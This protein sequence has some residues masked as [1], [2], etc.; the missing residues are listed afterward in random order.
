MNDMHEKS[1]GVKCLYD[2]WNSY[3]VVDT[4]TGLPNLYNDPQ[5]RIFL[6]ND[7]YNPIKLIKKCSEVKFK[8]IDISTMEIENEELERSD[9]FTS[10]L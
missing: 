10:A 8:I 5:L 6:L 7:N 9:V 4:A 2:Q 3:S 1:L